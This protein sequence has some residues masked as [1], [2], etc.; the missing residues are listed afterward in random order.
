MTFAADV[1]RNIAIVGQFGRQIAPR[2]ALTLPASSIA[3]GVGRSSEYAL[4]VAVPEPREQRIWF[5]A[6]KRGAEPTRKSV[7][8]MSSFEFKKSLL[9]SVGAVYDR[10]SFLESTKYAR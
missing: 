6:P 8:K 1:L 5:A 2:P 3:S 9:A 10:A 7:K 4:Y